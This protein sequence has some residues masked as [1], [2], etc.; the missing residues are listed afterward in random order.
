MLA[1]RAATSS[2]RRRGS[3]CVRL[4]PA[5]DPGRAQLRLAH[6]PG[7]LEGDEVYD[8][9]FGENWISVDKN[10]DYDDTLAIHRTVEDTRACTATSRPTC[11]SASRRCSAGRA[12]RSW[13][14]PADL[15]LG[16]FWARSRGDRK[17]DRGHRGHHRRVAQ[18]LGGPPRTSRWRS[19]SPRHASTTSSRV[20]CASGPPRCWPAR[21]SRPLPR[22]QGLRRAR[23]QHPV[24]AQQPDRRRGEP[25]DHPGRWPRP[26]RA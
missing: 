4:G 20:T 22:R 15:R 23:V 25:A 3:R 19:T 17:G 13:C 18:L 16:P 26:L 1:H 10:V 14:G 9:Y 5:R 21:R 7:A 11:A 8:P 24:G 12:S 2:R 6:R